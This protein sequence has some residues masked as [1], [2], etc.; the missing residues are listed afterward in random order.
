[1]DRLNAQADT[2]HK[3]ISADGIKS[4]DKKETGVS[5]DSTG[6]F[7][8]GDP[9]PKVG[10][11]S[12]ASSFAFNHEVDDISDLF[13]NEDGYY[14]LQVKQKLKKGVQPLT[15]VRDKIVQTLTDSLRIQKAEKRFEDDVKKMTDKTDIASLSK[16]DPLITTGKTD[17]V[18]RAQF[19]PQ[20]GYNNQAAA[21]AF[22]LK[23]GKTSGVIRTKEALFVV[24]PLW[25][26][27]LETI[28]WTGNEI[29]GLRQK[30]ESEVGQKM[31]VEWYLGLKAR[32]KIIDNVNQFYMD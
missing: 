8:R 13:E 15:V 10:Y 31:Y 28:P 18:I 12:G 32:A 24:K 5:V 20:V 21:A 19:I 27:L 17:T 23:E 2:L 7:K 6:L 11:V 16:I 9:M 3:L 22:A 1:M 14:I 26:K 30:M 4:L 29:A 25:H